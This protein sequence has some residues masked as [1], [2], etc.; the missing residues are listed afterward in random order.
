[1]IFLATLL[2]PL[3]LQVFS[4]EPPPPTARRCRWRSIR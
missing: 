1:M 4:E 2:F 3:A